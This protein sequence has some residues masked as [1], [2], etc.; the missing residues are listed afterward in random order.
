MFGE[1]AAMKS[2]PS[3]SA[4]NVRPA[5]RTGV[6]ASAAG[7]AFGVSWAA[8]VTQ[9]GNAPYGTWTT[10]VQCWSQV[11]GLPCRVAMTR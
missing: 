3:R 1:Y 2:R 5:H 11:P 4:A 8:S 9:A 7:T 10:P 6:F